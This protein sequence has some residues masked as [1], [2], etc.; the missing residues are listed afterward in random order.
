MN[1]FAGL[2]SSQQK[3]PRNNF[4]SLHRIIKIYC[5]SK[6]TNIGEENNNNNSSKTD[7]IVIFSVCVQILFTY[8]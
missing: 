3:N 7:T 4:F 1:I 6:M 2:G 5:N 8:S